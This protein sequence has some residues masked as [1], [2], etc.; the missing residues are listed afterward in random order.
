MIISNANNVI[1]HTRT[2]NRPP[3]IGPQSS[4][5]SLMKKKTIVLK[6]DG[7]IDQDKSNLNQL[8]LREAT[9]KVISKVLTQSEGKNYEETKNYEYV[10][11]QYR[12]NVGLQCIFSLISIIASVI[13]Y[14]ASIMAKSQ[15]VELISSCICF[16]SSG[17]L[18]MSLIF[19]YYLNNR[20]KCITTKLPLQFVQTRWS[21]VYLAITIAI[22]FFHP[23][24]FSRAVDI[25]FYNKK[26]NVNYKISLNAFFTLLCM[27]RMWFLVKYHLVSSIYFEPRTQRICA[28]NGFNTNLFFSFKGCVYGAP[29]NIYAI[30][31]TIIFFFFSYAI[32]IFERGVEEKTKLQFSNY[33]NCL[34]CLIITMTT[35]GYGDYTPST[36]LGQFLVIVS[37]FCGVMLLSMLIVAIT[38]ILNLT[39]NEKSIYIML[40]RIDIMNEKDAL[41]SRLV[42]RYTNLYRK[43]R[44][45]ETINIVEEK[46]MFRFAMHNFKSKCKELQNSFP[47][48]NEMDNIRENLDFLGDTI[49]KVREEH[50]QLS[51][52]ADQIMHKMNMN[53][54]NNN[55]KY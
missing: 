29:F 20:V 55:P 51:G 45:K 1:V 24:P 23:F 53:N 2:N 11:L 18:Y 16:G 39:G 15:N 33:W 25:D 42:S 40:E 48:Y 8:S 44:N 41:A 21:K 3:T 47:A 46:D 38:N 6:Q 26:F 35:V 49:E 9:K 10:Y 43:M 28:M 52:L 34:W 22:F 37:C 7:Q 31:F 27:F 19:D 50:N 5:N 14:E 54:N 30:L 13:N 4:T 12:Y 36:E 32:R 17:L